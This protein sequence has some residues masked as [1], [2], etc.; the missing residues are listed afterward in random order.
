M[1][2]FH[3]SVVAE[4]DP[5]CPDTSEARPRLSVREVEKP[6]QLPARRGLTG[7][8]NSWDVQKNSALLLSRKQQ[9]V[10]HGMAHDMAVA[11][12]PAGPHGEGFSNHHLLADV[13]AVP[14]L[15]ACLI[16]FPFSR[17]K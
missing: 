17:N 11:A 1:E 4:R 7:H 8:D 6:R 2:S 14:V 9:L 5:Y 10:G 3:S 16:S 13:T 15:A 12:E